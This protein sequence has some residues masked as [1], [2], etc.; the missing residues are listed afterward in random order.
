MKITTTN[1]LTSAPTITTGGGSTDDPANLID[2]DFAT[3]FQSSNTTQL[4]ASFG[5]VGTINYVA[6]AGMNIEGS[7]NYTSEVRTY[8]GATL[9]TRVFVKTNQPVVMAFDAQSFSNLRIYLYNPS[10]TK[11]IARY[12]AAGTLLEI[13]NSGEQSGYVRQHLVANYKNR[14]TLNA[15]SEPTSIVRKRIQS[16][17]KLSIPN[18]TRSFSENEWQLFVNFALTDMFFI[19]ER[20]AET[21]ATTGNNI[22]PAAY[23]GYDIDKVNVT[24][25]SQ[26]R[27][28]NNISLSFK[29]TNGL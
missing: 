15:Q 23:I 22:A 17:G 26:T 19:L 27:A 11:P 2:Q 9:I 25:H 20:D 1:V 16:K 29:V 3:S 4:I 18:V 14:A 6:V 10:G 13:P 7:K 8:D 12:M 21:D 28:L 5:A 24:A